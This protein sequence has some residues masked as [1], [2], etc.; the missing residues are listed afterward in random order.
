MWMLRSISNLALAV[1]LLPISG[2]AAESFKPVLPLD[3]SWKMPSS[4]GDLSDQKELIPSNAATAKAQTV[5]RESLQR[6]SRPIKPADQAKEIAAMRQAANKLGQQARLI[7]ELT[8]ARIIGGLSNT[9]KKAGKPN[10]NWRQ[11]L[12]AACNAAAKIDETTHEKTA[13]Q[14]VTMW[15]RIEGDSASWTL[16][17]IDLKAQRQFDFAKAITERQAIQDWSKG[18]ESAAFKKYRS[19]AVT[20]NASPQG[21]ALDMR[22]IELERAKFRQDKQVRRWQRALMDTADKYQDK[23][24]LGAGN[25]GKVERLVSAVTKIHRELIDFLIREASSSKAS[26][27]QRKEA[28]TAIERYLSTNIPDNEKFRVRI[29]SGE[30]QYLAGQHKAAANT[31]AGIANE[32]QGN[33][34]IDIWRR[35]IRSQ[36]ELADWPKDAPWNDIPK[37]SREARVVLA[38]MYKRIDRGTAADW[39]TVAHVGLLHVATGNSED[40]FAVWNERLQKF[41]SGGHAARAAG[42]MGQTYIKSKNWDAL[43]SLGRIMTKANLTAI[44]LKTAY[45]PKELLGIALLEN[46]L[47]ALEANDYKKAIAKLDEYVKGWRGDRRHDEGFY[48]LAVAYHGDRQFRNAVTTMVAFTKMHTKSK[49]R[50]DAL[51]QGGAWTLALT[52]EDHVMYFLETHAL[53]FPKDRQSISSLQILAD[54]YMGREIYDSAIR[55]MSI[56]VGR[57]DLD[58][59]IRHDVARRLLDTAARHGSTATALRTA[60]KL[61][62]NFKNDTLITATALSVKARAFADQRNLQGLNLVDKQIRGLDQSL[63]GVS[64]LVSEIRFLLADTSALNKFKEPVSSLAARDPKGQLEKGYAEF[65]ELD[66]LYR[67]AC[68]PVRTGW[69]GPAMHRSARLGEEFLKAYDDLD[70]AKT[71]D[72]EDVTSFRNRK[73]TII[74]AVDNLV[75]ESDEKSLEQAKAGATNPDW[76]TAIMWQNGND[77]SHP[78]F[79]SDTSGHFIQWHAR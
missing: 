46:G 25:E 16:P 18:N 70:I 36:T 53:E 42:W 3:S 20:Y 1:V 71:L 34:A 62:S 22:I 8:A 7:A 4:S 57:N 15:R 52:W 6:L 68:L 30:I 75:L 74:E 37:G 17:P 5:F 24:F 10:G 77:W 69:C 19:L 14:A 2:F 28:L 32:L 65:T 33:Q 43:E 11:H 31:F 49:Y 72:P 73:K 54:L 47:N 51:I 12:L 67:S 29:A 45:R 56:L 66:Q 50:H 55:V 23:Q 9:G 35:A 39:A 60:D 44:H 58:N 63:P 79:T 41:P 26:D 21:A 78:K 27:N 48:S 38:G 76:T 61:L 40:A 59:G 64:E 13:L